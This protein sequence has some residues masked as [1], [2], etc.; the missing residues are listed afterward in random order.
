MG[1][2]TEDRPMIDDRRQVTVGGLTFDVRIG[3]PETGPWVLLLHGFPVNG[4][5]YDDVLPRLHESGLRTLVIDQRGYSPGARPPGV[6]DYRLTHLVSDVIGVLDALGIGYAILVGH[7]WGGIVAWHL[8]GKYPDRFTGLVVASTGHP[9]AMRDALVG[10]DQRERSSYILDFVADG[11]EERLL[12][13]DAAELQ[14]VGIS[15]DELAPLREPGALTAA[16]N[17]YRANFTGDIKATMACPPV[18]IPTT[19]L[20]SDAD[21]A[22]GR[23]QAQGSGRYVYGD[24][25]YCELAGVDHWIPQRAAPALAS[26]IALRSTIF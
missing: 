12:A 10:S 3:G 7:D 4:S 20:W 18:E 25:R 14:A 16:L 23:E 26:E 13:D 21:T 17:W 6:D 1:A 5:C 9:S 8:A 11:A 2:M 22:L 19:L 15:E 24:F